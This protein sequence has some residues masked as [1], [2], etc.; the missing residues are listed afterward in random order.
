M[1]ET[2]VLSPLEAAKSLAPEI[3]SCAGAT[4]AARELPRPLFEAMADAGIF[5]M[6]IPRALGGEEIDLP[7]YVQVIE[8]IAK[9]DAST[10]WVTNQTAI[11][12]TFA[13][14]MPPEDAR[15]IWMDTPRCVISNTP[16]PTAQA[17]VVPGGFRVTGEQGYS[18][19]CRHASW[20]ASR[21]QVI[22]HGS[23]RLLDNGQPETRLLFV[24]IGEA[25]LLDTWHVRGLRGTGTNHFAVR[26][27]FVPDNRTMLD[28]GAPLYETGPLYQLP[29][30]LL[31]AS[32][33]A[34]VA[35]G[36]A[37]SCL[38]AFIELAAEKSPRYASVGGM[39]CDQPLVQ[40]DVGLADAHI[41]AGRALLT[42]TIREVWD[43]VSTTGTVS[44]DQRVGLRTAATHTIRLA[45]D[46]VDLVYN[47]AGA[48]SIY[49]GHP[50]QRA[51]QDIHVISQHVQSRR[52]HYELVGRYW[53]G[54]PVPEGRF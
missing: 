49:D 25:E 12:A 10:A 26:D 32:G 3:R 51:F 15:A 28:V 13:A 30:T 5:H 43:T 24:P 11:F 47:A 53:L 37:R 4:E 16:M 48:T 50:I 46:A 40:A 31:F 35:L 36:T 8:E 1:L 22:E 44:L 27:V 6:A 21:A 39:L 54:V 52:A 17:V 42:E 2:G 14:R 33:D 29:R 9:A 7:T 20:I 38:S 18:T 19:G 34:S 23:P 41:R 45:I